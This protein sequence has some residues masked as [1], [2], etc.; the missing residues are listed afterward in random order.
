MIDSMQLSKMMMNYYGYSEQKVSGREQVT[1]FN[2]VFESKS[3]ASVD[4]ARTEKISMESMLD[5]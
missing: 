2:G 4:A 3:V 1:S 5:I